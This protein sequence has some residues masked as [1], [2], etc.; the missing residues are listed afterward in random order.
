M[1]RA[2]LLQPFFGHYDSPYQKFVHLEADMTRL[3]DVS[4]ILQFH[5]ILEAHGLG[6]Q[7]FAIVNAKLIDQ[8]LI[9]KTGTVADATLLT[10]PSSTKNDKPNWLICSLY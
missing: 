6:Q 2:Q 9:S 4:S 7:I 10:P 5:H 8:G 1:L 3:P